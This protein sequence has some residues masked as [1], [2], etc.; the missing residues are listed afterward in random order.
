M[1]LTPPLGEEQFP[2][3]LPSVPVGGRLTQFLHHWEKF[4]TDVWV[5]SVIRGGLD[6]VFQ[7][8]PPLSDSPIP[9]SQTSDKEKFRL[10]SEEVQ[11]LLLKSVIE[12][13]PPT[14]STPGFYSRLFLVPKK[15]GGMRLVIDLSIL[16]SYLSVPHFKMETNRSIRACILPG[17]LTTKLDLSDAYFHIPI[18]LASRKFLRFVWNNKVYQFLAVPFGLA[19]A[20]QV[21]TR[22]FQTVIA[23][24]HTLSIQA[25]SYLDDSLLK[26]FDSEILSRHTFLF[27]RLLLDLGFLISWKKSQILPSQ[28]FLFLGEHYRTDLGLI[29]S[30]RGKISVTLSE[31][32]YFQQ[33]SFSH[34]STILSTTGLSEFSSRCGSSRSPSHSTSPVLSSGTLGLCFSSLGGSSTYSSCRTTSPRLVDS[35]GKCFDRCSFASPSSFSNSVYRFQSSGM[36]SLSR[37]KVCVGSVVSCSAT[38]THQ[39]ARDESCPISVTTFQDSSSFESSSASDGQYNSSGLLAESRRNSLSCSLSSLQRNSSSLSSITHSSGSQAYSRDLQCTGRLSVSLPQSS[40]HRMGTTASSVRLSCSAVGSSSCRSLCYQSESQTGNLCISSSRPSV[41][42]SRRHVSLLGRN[43]RLC[44]SSIP[45][46]SS[47]ASQDQA[48]GLQDH[49]Y[50]TS[51]AKTSMVSRTSASVLCQAS[52]TSFQTRPSVSVQGKSGT[53]KA[54][55]SSSSR[56]ATLREGLRQKGFSEGATSHISKSVRQSTGIVYEAKWAIFCDWC[57][58]RDI[59]PVRVTVQQ[60]ADFLVYLFEIKRLVPSTIK[61]Y[62]S[63]IGR[64]ISLLGGPDFGQNEYISLL[65]R[66][67]S[68][69]RPKQNKLVPQWNLGLVLAALNSPPFE[70]AEEVDLRFLYYKCCF[71]LALASGRRRSEIHAFSVSDSCLRFNRNKS[72]VTLL[73]DPCFLGKNQIPDRGAEPVIIPALSE[74][75]SS[76]LSCPIRILSIYLDRTKNSHPANNTRLFLPLKKGISDISAK[77]ISS[78]ICRTILLAYESSGEKFLNRHAVKA[79]GVRAL[80]SSWALFNSASISEVLSAGFWR[81]QDSFTSFYLRSMSAQADSLFS[82]GPIVAAQHVSVPLVSE[83][84][85][86][87]AVC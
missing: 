23:H 2:V 18:S 39:F 87:S 50:C 41:L 3:P 21:F 68:L 62:R 69:E 25:H 66:S 8:R 30:P 70:P 80:A 84:S 1:L 24:L 58:G 51:L 42:R 14:Q 54:R 61:G 71:L 79:H 64:T 53:S 48:I 34:G 32:S 47:S 82:L 9:M 10:L 5:L 74:D 13:I 11:S 52:E 19:V 35:Q 22:V 16:N 7:E 6:L 76:R 78:W 33:Q 60:L 31:N 85:G 72:S 77:T 73:T 57:S 63:A 46:S 55:V 27:I 12:E 44:L 83:R 65:V 67:F 56:L 15:T 45:L 36:G 40:Q 4:T 28:D 37:G 75:A 38:R 26:E 59:D 43:V 17:M 20:P 81:C 86:D 29:F 49:S